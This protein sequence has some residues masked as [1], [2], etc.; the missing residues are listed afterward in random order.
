VTEPLDAPIPYRVVYAE[1]VRKALRKLLALARGLGL[2][3]QVL[4]AV[5]ELDDRL[6]IY[7]QFGQPLMDLMHEPAQIWIGVVPP[8]VVHYAIYEER[9][10]VIVATPISPLPRSGL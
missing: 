10:L 8:L 2:G 4:D 1:R 5:K 3:Q 6:H 9:R 7:P